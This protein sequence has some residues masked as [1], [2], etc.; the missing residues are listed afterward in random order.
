[1]H[2]EIVLEPKEVKCDEDSKLKRKLLF[3]PRYF[4]LCEL[5]YIRHGYTIRG[6][7][8]G[9]HAKDVKCIQCQ[10]RFNIMKVN[11]LTFTKEG[12][13]KLFE[14]ENNAVHTRESND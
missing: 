2:I 9:R 13:T 12:L 4:K 3:P 6:R 8:R 7:L 5:S 1:M 10:M 11:G 14:L